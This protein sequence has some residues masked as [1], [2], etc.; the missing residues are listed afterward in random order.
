[1]TNEPWGTK[2]VRGVTLCADPAREDCFVVVHTDAEME[3]WP[4]MSAHARRERL[5]R[6]F[7]V[8]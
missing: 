1:V 7:I 6:G 3:D 8:T 5:H 2:N 4:G